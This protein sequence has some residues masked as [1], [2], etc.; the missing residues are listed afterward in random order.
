MNSNAAAFADKGTADQKATQV[1]GTVMNWNT[2]LNK[3]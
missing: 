2:L 3:L 1:S